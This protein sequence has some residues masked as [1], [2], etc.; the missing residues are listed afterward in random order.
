LGDEFLDSGV[1]GEQGEV[2]AGGGLVV[3]VGFGLP[4]D[5]HGGPPAVGDIGETA[6]L[7]R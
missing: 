5:G 3:V 6:A 4:A 1:V 7:S 2:V